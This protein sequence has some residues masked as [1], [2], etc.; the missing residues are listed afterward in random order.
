MLKI[1]VLLLAIGSVAVA[2][3]KGKPGTGTF[4]DPE[5]LCLGLSTTCQACAD[6]ADKTASLRNAKSG[7][8]IPDL[9]KCMGAAAGKVDRPE[10]RCTPLSDTCKV[11]MDEKFYHVNT[12]K[13]IATTLAGCFFHKDDEAKDPKKKK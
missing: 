8:I 9:K 7:D 5:L 2:A 12:K 1:L 13:P 3:P 6:I 10:K 4:A 11:C